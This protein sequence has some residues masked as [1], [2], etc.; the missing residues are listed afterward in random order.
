MQ[1]IPTETVIRVLL[2]RAGGQTCALDLSH[3]VEIMRPLPVRAVAGAPDMVRGLS[4]VRGVPLP[5][6]ALDRV[7]LPADLPPSTAATHRFVVV[8]TGD[9]QVALAVDAVLGVYDL[10]SSLIGGIPPLIEHAAGE[11]I[12]AIGALDSELLMVLSAGRIVPDEAWRS[13]PPDGPEP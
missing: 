13:L 5:V 2:V 10:A 12:E 4:T 8:R 3:V 1:A 9:R 7:L 11:A 6:V